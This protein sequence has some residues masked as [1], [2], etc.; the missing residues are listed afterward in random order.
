VVAGVGNIY[1]DEALHLARLVPTQKGSDT[2]RPQANR[3]RDA[4]VAVLE[5]AIAARGR[6]SAIMS[7]NRVWRADSSIN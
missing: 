6:P 3:L 4:I 1:A 2:T 5:K 7:R